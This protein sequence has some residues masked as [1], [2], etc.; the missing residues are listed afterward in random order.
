MRAY[1][2]K[3][4]LGNKQKVDEAL[5]GA[6]YVEARPLITYYRQ[7]LDTARASQADSEGSETRR[8]ASSIIANPGSILGATLGPVH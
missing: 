3:V 1:V 6:T 8:M 7:Q 2:E 5:R 4:E